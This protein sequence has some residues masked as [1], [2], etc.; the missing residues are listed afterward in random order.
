MS[1]FS[2]MVSFEL[3]TKVDIKKVLE[4]TKLFALAVSLGG[5]ESLIEHP[6]SMTQSAIPATER[7]KAGLSEWLIRLSVGIEDKEDLIADLSGALD[8][9][10]E[11]GKRI[12]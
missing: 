5:V 8:Q 3:S 2:G 6:W 7:L 9:G 10:A 1:G 11:A 4:S 12:G